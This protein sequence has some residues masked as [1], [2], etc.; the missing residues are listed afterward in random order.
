[1]VSSREEPPPMIRDVA[2]WR[3]FEAARIAAQ[4]PNYSQNVRLVE[5]M[6]E[7]ARSL[8]KFTTDDVMDGLDVNLRLAALLRRTARYTPKDPV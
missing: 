6:Y 5:G 8:G 1:M 7:L 2:R 4:K 3:E